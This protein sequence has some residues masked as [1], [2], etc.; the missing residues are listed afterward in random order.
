M[1]TKQRLQQAEKIEATGPPLELP[2][3]AV[4]QIGDTKIIAIAHYQD[5]GKNCTE[6]LV[7]LLKNEVEKQ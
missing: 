4:F 2:T 6:T 3:Q 7:N 1:N 5:K